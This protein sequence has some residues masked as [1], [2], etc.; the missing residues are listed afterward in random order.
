M[1]TTEQK[2]KC[3]KCGESISIDDVL[4]HQ[5]E[6]KIKKELGEENRSKEIEIVRQKKEL[7]DQK[8]KLEEAQKNAE[9]EINKKV[10]EKLAT[11]RVTVWKK[12]QIEAEKQ[13]TGER[14]LLEEQIKDKDAKLKEVTTEALQARA[15][16]QKFENEKKSFELEKEK[17]IDG[18]RKKIEEDAFTRATKQ[19]ERDA[20]KLLKR[21]EDS[22]KER[23]A[24]RKMLEE[25]LVEKDTE[26]KEAKEN[27]LQVRKDKNKFE[28]EKK[29]FEL[30]KQ[31]QFDEE[32]KNIFEEANRKAVEAEQYKIA[33]LEKKLSDALKANEEQKRKLEQGSQQTQ[34]EVLELELEESL[35]TAFPYDEIAPVAKGVRGADVI[36]RVFDRFNRPCGQIVWESKNTQAWKNEWIQKLRDNQ[37]AVK[38]DLAVIVSVVLP[39]D[40]KGFALRDGV[41]ICDIKLAIALA[42]ALRMTL[43]VVI[44]EKALSIGKDEKMEFLHA[45]LTG[46]EFK[47]RVEAI[48]EAFSNMDEG[49]KKER[50]AYEKIWSE[51]EK[52]IKKVITNTVGMYGDLSGLVTLPQIKML[53][54]PEGDNE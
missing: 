45:Y 40:V 18:E 27:E 46:V 21:L 19:N 51:R 9:I 16:R 39:D 31:R 49:L 30:E 48:L 50:M 25:R 22:E 14:K 35:K 11:E 17:Q 41:W 4:T 37:R 53:E 36:Q 2:I 43:E 32:R 6:E 54:L 38:A 34:G 44:R 28:E 52:Q 26:L 5:I 42:T 29:D 33:Q 47:Q 10:G 8:N 13:K 15:D 7:E 23:E 12:A 3:P 20:I 24:E 1:A